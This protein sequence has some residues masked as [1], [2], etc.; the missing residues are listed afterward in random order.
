MK[1]TLDGLLFPLP[2]TYPDKAMKSLPE[3]NCC[4]VC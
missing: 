3:S 2:S 4:R 1:T